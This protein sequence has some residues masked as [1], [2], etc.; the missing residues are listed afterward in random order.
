MD[1][2][3]KAYTVTLCALFAALTAVFS[4]IS[5]PIGPVPINL[6]LLAVLL[7]GT[8]PGAAHWRTVIPMA[9]RAQ[10]YCCICGRN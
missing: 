4:W 10:F 8:V 2:G 3:S 5:V 1:K 9:R 7:R 6:A